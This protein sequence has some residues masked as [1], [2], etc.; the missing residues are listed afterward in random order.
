M[1]YQFPEAPILLY[2]SLAEKVGVEAAVLMSLYQQ[3]WQRMRALTGASASSELFMSRSQWLSLSTFWDEE[4]LAQLTN[5]LVEHGLID[6]TYAP[7]GR[8]SIRCIESD[9]ENLEGLQTEEIEIVSRLPVVDEVE[10]VEVSVISEAPA[11]PVSEHT[12]QEHGLLQDDTPYYP[13]SEPSISQNHSTQRDSTLIDSTQSPRLG[14]APT[15]GGSIGWARKA[16]QMSSGHDD[17]LQAKFHQ[18]EQLRKQLQPMALGWQP[19]QNFYALLPRHNIAIQ[20]AHSCLDE[21][22]LY[23]LDK[24]RKETNWDQKFL[25]WVKREWVRKQTDEGRQQR[26]S[27]EQ[28]AGF[29]NENPRRDTRENR[30]RVTAAVMDIKDTDW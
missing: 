24:D 7:D 6:A 8:V 25:G 30:K 3:Q 18:E 28:K 15:F 19:S 29:S 10:V 12:G 2:P 5:I 9:G 13:D 17:E 27:K 23:W 21:F 26:L 20:F 22:V 11:Q 16:Q 4:I 14:P 1:S